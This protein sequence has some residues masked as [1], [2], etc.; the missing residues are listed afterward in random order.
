MD[1]NSN[2]LQVFFSVCLFFFFFFLS[3]FLSL[4]AVCTLSHNACY[5]CLYV[6]FDSS[7]GRKLEESQKNPSSA[8]CDGCDIR[9]CVGKRG[10]STNIAASRFRGGVGGGEHRSKSANAASA[11][12]QILVLIIMGNWK[13]IWIP[14]Y[15]FLYKF[16]AW[17]TF[18]ALEDDRRRTSEANQCILI[19]WITAEL[20]CGLV[21]TN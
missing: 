6:F 19:Y 8:I 4:P 14:F 18:V 1:S 11:L 16:I 9:G 13:N 5:S 20:D 15:S 17:K 3:F 7:L 2:C 10:K 12:I 21:N